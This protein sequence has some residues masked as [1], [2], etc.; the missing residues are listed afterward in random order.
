MSMPLFALSL[1]P[2]LHVLE[3]KLT[4]IRISRRSRKTAVV[5]YAD[6]III[7]VTAPKDIPAIRDAIWSHERAKGAMLNIQKSKAMAVGA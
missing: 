5:A 3:Q 4:G 2:L 1:N 7:F 6:D